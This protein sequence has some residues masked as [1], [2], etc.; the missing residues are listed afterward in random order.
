MY[1]ERDEAPQLT[2]EE[3]V[4]ALSKFPSHHLVKVFVEGHYHKIVTD[5]KSIGFNEVLIV[6][7]EAK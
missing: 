7:R 5:A 3:L 6:T 2:V 1:N 4:K